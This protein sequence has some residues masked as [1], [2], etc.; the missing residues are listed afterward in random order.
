MWSP[1]FKGPSTNGL[2][3]MLFRRVIDYLLIQHFSTVS[4]SIA[5][6]IVIC[7][8]GP[9]PL[10][11]ILIEL[12]IL[13]PNILLKEKLKLW[14][15]CAVIFVNDQREAVLSTNSPDR[16]SI[17]C[18]AC[19]GWLIKLRFYFPFFSRSNYFAN[20]LNKRDRISRE[21]DQGSY[22]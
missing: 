19:S 21:V 4:I 10:P 17:H 22:I 9:Y 2:F 3:K 14:A 12:F 11:Y 18:M 6:S 5:S 7:I 8:S 16:T 13:G 1:K 15:L 20:N